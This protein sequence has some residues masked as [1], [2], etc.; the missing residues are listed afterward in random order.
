LTRAVIPCVRNGFPVSATKPFS[1][2][3]PHLRDSFCTHS[4][5]AS[6]CPTKTKKI[7]RIFSNHEPILAFPQT[8]MQPLLNLDVFK[9]RVRY[10]ADAVSSHSSPK[11]PKVFNTPAAE[12]YTSR[13]EYIKRLVCSTHSNISPEVLELLTKLRSVAV[14]TVDSIDTTYCLEGNITTVADDLIVEQ[15]PTDFNILV[16]NKCPPARWDFAICAELAFLLD[17]NTSDLLLLISQPLEV[18]EAHLAVQETP[19]V[20]FPETPRDRSWLRGEEVASLPLPITRNVREKKGK[21][22]KK[23]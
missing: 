12:K 7:Q 2:S 20:R 22:G 11:G 16:S 6:M 13:V 9:S 14:L 1:Q 19:E 18:V 8:L 15:T 23:K 10:L 4:G 3:T 5:T 17:I 21:K